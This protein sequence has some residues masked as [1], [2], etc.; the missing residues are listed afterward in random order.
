MPTI[1][2]NERFWGSQY[3]WPQ[4]GDEWSKPWGGTQNVWKFVIL[5]RIREFL[6]ARTI[7]EI[8]P[9]YGRWTQFL[10]GSCE[11]LVAVDVS[12]KCV[13]NCRR[14]F[15]QSPRAQFLHND[16]R[17]LPLTDDASVDFIFSFDSL[18]HAEADVLEAY[19]QESARVLVPGGA[20]FIHHSNLGEYRA[21]V[22]LLKIL[23]HSI[24]HA[25]QQIYLLPKVH[26]RAEGVTAAWV[27]S[28]C[29]HSGMSPVKQEIIN[30]RNGPFLIDCFTIFRNSPGLPGQ[31]LRD[32]RFM[33]EARRIRKRHESTE[34]R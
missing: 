30:W 22:N 6:P 32:R 2:Q 33:N 11:R 31:V 14:G 18:V 19:L 4:S 20:G 27:S 17:S 23:P 15:A 29:R 9:G 5:P 1:E 34:K 10:L 16:G 7:L 24:A 3:E 26:W 28:A 12:I 13:E 21:S 8:A 25:G